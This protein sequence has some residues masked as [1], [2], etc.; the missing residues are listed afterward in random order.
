[1]TDLNGLHHALVEAATVRSLLVASDFDGVLAPIVADPAA[2]SARPASVEALETLAALNATSVA[3]V[4]GRDYRTLAG[5]V[6]PSAP[7]TLI[8]SHGAEVGPEGAAL[9]DD[10]QAQL[11][12]VTA[13][14]HALADRH[15]GFHVETKP[16][17]V[18]A[19]LRRVEGD[20]T[21]AAE[22]VDAL[23]ETWPAKVVSGK[24]VVE[25]TVRQVTKGDAVTALADSLQAEAVVYLGDDVTDEDV[26]TVLGPTDVGIKVG[27]GQTAARHRVADPSEVTTVLVELARA[28]AASV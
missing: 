25:F 13:E 16:L 28:R 21:A 23:V 12:R 1:M 7:F 11:A 24:E 20:A 22:A 5:F 26:F 4:S 18:A 3:V 8:G 17:S 9:T 27:E 15:P 6:G 10:E 14:L 2:V 19:H